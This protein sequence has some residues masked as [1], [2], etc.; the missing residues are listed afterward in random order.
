M[1]ADVYYVEQSC[2]TIDDI[3]NLIFGLNNKFGEK[4]ERYS[5]VTDKHDIQYTTTGLFNAGQICR[6]RISNVE[7]FISAEDFENVF[8]CGL[9]NVTTSNNI[10]EEGKAYLR[11]CEWVV[12]F[13][14][15]EYSKINHGGVQAPVTTTERRTIVSDVSLL[16]LEF[17]T[18]G[19][20]YNLG[21]VDNKQTGSNNPVN[22]WKVDVKGL[23]AVAVVIAVC[24]VIL[25]V[26]LIVLF[27]KTICRR[28]S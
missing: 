28:K 22:D 19:K 16:R 21:V 2:E 10:N 12:R 18:D 3:I 4:I 11:E 13:A 9:F 27:I 20:A 8:A 17:E 25:A 15:T 14:E 24:I 1:E 26:V 5:Y 7:D 6:D 23:N